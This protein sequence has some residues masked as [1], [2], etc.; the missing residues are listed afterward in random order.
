M[1]VGNITQLASSIDIAIAKMQAAKRGAKLDE[2]AK[3]IQELT[4][5]VLARIDAMEARLMA[6][7]D[8]IMS[9]LYTL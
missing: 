7:L 3:S 2:D 4:D 9:K 1:E 5:R 8:E 6:R